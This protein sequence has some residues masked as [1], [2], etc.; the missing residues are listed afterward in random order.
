MVHFTFLTSEIDIRPILVVLADF[1]T[2]KGMVY[3]CQNLNFIANSKSLAQIPKNEA[4]NSLTDIKSTHLK[5][6]LLFW[7]SKTF[8]TPALEGHNFGPSEQ[9]INFSTDSENL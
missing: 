8:F 9:I 4:L 2:L 5:I 3:Q 6:A 1:R 7:N